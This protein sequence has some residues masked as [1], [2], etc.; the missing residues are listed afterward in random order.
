MSFVQYGIYYQDPEDG[1][2]YPCTSSGHRYFSDVH[3][4][5]ALFAS[6][7]N[8]AK[9][10][11]RWIKDSSAHSV[12]DEIEIVDDQGNDRVIKPIPYDHIKIIPI[13]LTPDPLHGVTGPKP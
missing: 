3:H 9:I 4:A 10:I 5:P 11:R 1:K 2:L 8:A 13:N 7:K 12:Y 6:D